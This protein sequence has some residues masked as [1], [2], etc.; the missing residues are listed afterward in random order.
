MKGSLKGASAIA[1]AVVML[2]TASCGGGPRGFYESGP[3][4]VPLGG[5]FTVEPG[6]KVVVFGVRSKYCGME[7]P[8]FETAQ[9]EMFSGPGSQGPAVGEVY[10][11]GIGQAV[12]VLCGGS[13]PVRAIGYQAPEGFEGE[14]AMSFYGGDQAT[15]TV[16][17]PKPDEEPAEEP[18]LNPDE[19]SEPAPLADPDV[20]PPNQEK[21]EPIPEAGP[22]EDAGPQGPQLNN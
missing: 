11:A 5:N 4:R 16:A 2:A 17:A 8:S 13:V 14:V 20:T 7:P 12:A 3:P 18:A 1:A 15:V 10:D 22:P 6:K 21:P 19:P 9:G